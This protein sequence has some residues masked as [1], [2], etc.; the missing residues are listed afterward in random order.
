MGKRPPLD[1]WSKY[2]YPLIQNITFGGWVITLRTLS[3]VL[4]SF[5][6][7]KKSFSKQKCQQCLSFFWSSHD[8]EKSSWETIDHT[9]YKRSCKKTLAQERASSVAKDTH[10]P[11][12]ITISSKRLNGQRGIW[13]LLDWDDSGCVRSTPSEPP[14]QPLLPSGMR[15]RRPTVGPKNGAPSDPS[16]P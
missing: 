1:E 12:V 8:Q 16:T 15:R 6:L 2:L 14:L 3:I 13:S 10:L 9:T 7:A 11:L 4:Q 5:G